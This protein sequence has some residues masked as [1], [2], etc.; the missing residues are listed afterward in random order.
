LEDVG[1]FAMVA[2]AAGVRLNQRLQLHGED[3]VAGQTTRSILQTGSATLP[4]HWVI[5]GQ[6]RPLF[7][8]T[9]LLSLALVRIA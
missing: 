1:G 4:T 3:A 6:G 8:T 2:G 7:I 9:F 5:D